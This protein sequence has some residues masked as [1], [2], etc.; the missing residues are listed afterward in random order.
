MNPEI[1]PPRFEHLLVVV[2]DRCAFIRINRPDKRNALDDATRGQL[3]TALDWAS[4]TDG[5]SVVVLAGEGGKSFASGADLTTPGEPIVTPLEI[6][7]R[8]S[9]RRVYDAVAQ[10]SRPVVAMIDGFCLGG[11]CELAMSADIR[12]ASTSAR[13]GQPE[14]RLGFIPG[15]GA[16]QRLPRLVGLGQAMRMVLT[17][18]VIDAAEAHRLGMIDILVEPEQLLPR[19]RELCAA[20]SRNSPVALA[21][22]KQALRASLEMPLRDGLTLERELFSLA[23]SSD[24]ATEG[25]AAFREQRSPRFTGR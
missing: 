15:G 16:T 21:L 13:L 3:I 9:G 8:L 22:A 24:D 6:R 12:V 25:V 20:M 2:E 10:C 14:I 4:A 1:S 19:T 18:D 17:G 5:I 7:D 23:F 11:G